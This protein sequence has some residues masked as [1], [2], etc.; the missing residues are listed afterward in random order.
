MNDFLVE[1]AVLRQQMLSA[2]STVLK[3]GRYILGKEVE[4]FEREWANFCRVQFCIGVGNGMDAIEIGLRALD[5]GPGDEVITTSITAFA[6]VLAIMRAGATPVLA[7]INPDTAMLEPKSV[8]RC[9]TS[10]TKAVILVHLY[11]QIGP[12]GELQVI[13]NNSGIHMI[14]DCAQAH[15]ARYKGQVAGSFGTFGAW[16]FYPTKNLGAIGDSGALTTSRSELAE[17]ASALRNYGQTESH[18][19]QRLGMNSRLDELQAAILRVRLNYLNNW[20]TRRREIAN[21]YR[22]R[23]KHPQVRLLP[24]ADQAERHVYHLF[25]I[26]CP[27]RDALQAHLRTQGIESLV[28]YPIPA[29][30][31][32]PCRSMPHDPFGL[33]YAERHAEECLSLPCHPGITDDQAEKVI[34][35]INSF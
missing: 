12:L 27:R 4:A 5:I 15:G 26:T 17:Q 24:G 3:S 35:A 6:T 7:D 20:T 8:L 34:Q 18:Y 19:H 16:S 31:Q 21:M 9:L 1:S 28:H 2:V 25:V 33:K 29:H 22:E 13:T 10:K 30:K 11:G 14:E 32:E 23:I